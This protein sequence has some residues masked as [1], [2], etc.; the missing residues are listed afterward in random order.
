LSENQNLDLRDI[1]QD[2]VIEKD[3]TLDPIGVAKIEENVSINL[4]NLFFDFD[5]AVLRPESFPELDRIVTL[6]SERPTMEIEISGHTDSAGP[7]QYN[8]SLSQRRANSVVQY[9]NGKKID[10]ARMN[11]VFFGE[12]QPVDTNDTSEGRRRNRRVEFKILKI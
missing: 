10:K 9:L 5:K 8:M 12:S 1:K 3:F 4:N 2:Q 7:D 6:M 11:V